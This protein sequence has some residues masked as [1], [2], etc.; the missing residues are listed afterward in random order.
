PRSRR[1]RSSPRWGSL[2]CWPLPRPCPRRH[3][4]TASARRCCW[5]TTSRPRR[6]SRGTEPCSRRASCRTCCL[7]RRSPR[8]DEPPPGDLALSCAGALVDQLA[9]LGLTDACLSP[10]SRSTA[11]ALALAR[12]PSIRLHV[13]LDERSSSFFALGLA[14]ATGRPV[15]VVTTSGT[16]VANLFPAVVEASLTRTPLILLTA[17]RPEE[18][19]GT[20]ANQTIDQFRIF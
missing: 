12:H 18:L 19:H 4:R 13:V 2:P 17:D 15:A 3:S 6:W 1:A 14:K 8:M 10:G 20:G 9:L 5:R 11:L 16:A 7:R